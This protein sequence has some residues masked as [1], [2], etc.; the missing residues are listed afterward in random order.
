MV[1]MYV[2]AGEFLL[3]ASSDDIARLLLLCPSCDPASLRDQSPQRRIY[4]ESYWIDRTEVTNA[5][6]AQF[7][8]QTGYV[9]TAEQMRKSYVLDPRTGEFRYLD[10]ADW[11][12]PRGPASDIRGRDQY[13]V[14]QISWDDAV[15]YCAWAGRRLPTEAEWEKAARGT[16]GRLFP[17]GNELPDERLLNFNVNIG[18]VVPVGSY[19]E[20]AS[21]YGALDMAGSLWEWVADYYSETY[22]GEALDRNPTGPST[23]EGH[24]FRGGSWASEAQTELV[25]VTTTFRLWNFPYI[26][27]DVLGF[28][29]ATSEP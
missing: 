5:Q 4:L 3:G 12:H 29:C 8:A 10:G 21:P 7:V 24:T 9:T 1:Q 18:D 13:P 28:R 2:P 15:A 26:R 27:S 22:Y 25:Y 11:R 6:F 16:D 14:T 23:G 20:G 17:W 19:P